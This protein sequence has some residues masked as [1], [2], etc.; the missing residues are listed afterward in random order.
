MR[1]RLLSVVGLAALLGPV[2]AGAAPPGA[3]AQEQLSFGV[4]MARRGL[5]N[6]ALFRFRQADRLDPD[7]PQILNNLA[8]ASEAT[9]QFEKALALYRRALEIS[10]GDRDLRRNFSRFIEFYQGL[11]PEGE[12][13]GGVEQA[14]GAAVEPGADP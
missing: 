10:P 4:E 7:N 1:R 14:G 9:G 12:A 13:A 11:K 5:W 8:V 3:S 6:E 2:I